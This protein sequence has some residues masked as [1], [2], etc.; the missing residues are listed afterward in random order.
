MP[1]K[2]ASGEPEK[3]QETAGGPPLVWD[4]PRDEKAPPVPQVTAQATPAPGATVT[5]ATVRPV[6]RF[7]AGD[8]LVITA[9][10]TEVDAEAAKRAYEAAERSHITLREI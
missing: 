1:D 8:G 3:P 5:L 9:D 7:D 10:G 6:V 2:A 4:M